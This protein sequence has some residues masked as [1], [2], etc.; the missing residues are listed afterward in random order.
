VASAEP[1]PS[2]QSGKLSARP[3]PFITYPA[4]HQL[5]AEVVVTDM[6]RRHALPAQHSGKGLSSPVRHVVCTRQL[7]GM[8]YSALGRKRS[9]ID[10]RTEIEGN[11]YVRP[12]V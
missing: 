3:A 12:G 11:L 8:P 1:E 5:P 4:Q 6:F 9:R 2:C 10:P 7:K